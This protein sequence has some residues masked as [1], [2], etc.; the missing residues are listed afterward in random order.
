MKAH[1]KLAR[2][3]RTRRRPRVCDNATMPTNEE[4]QAI[5]ERIARDYFGLDENMNNKNRGEGWPGI[6]S[7][8]E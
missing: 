8:Q 1:K 5:A 3:T 2:A 4:L 6:S 7:Y